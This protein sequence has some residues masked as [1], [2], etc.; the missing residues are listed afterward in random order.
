MA[1]RNNLT[2]EKMNRAIDIINIYL[3]SDISKVIHSS[4]IVYLLKDIYNNMFNYI[5]TPVLKE[6][7]D[8]IKLYF[9]YI[10]I[11]FYQPPKMLDKYSNYDVTY[12]FTFYY[13]KLSLIFF[14]RVF[15]E[16]K[17]KSLDDL[18]KDNQLILQLGIHFIFE[19]V[20]NNYRH[21]RVE[22]YIQ[23]MTNPKP[24][25]DF[26]KSIICGYL[27][28]TLIGLYAKDT[29][30][31]I[32]INGGPD[33]LDIESPDRIKYFEVKSSG[34]GEYGCQ[35]FFSKNKADPSR[36]Y[37]CLSVEH[38]TRMD[39]DHVFRFHIQVNKLGKSGPEAYLCDTLK[40]IDINASRL[41]DSIS[42][43]MKHLHYIFNELTTFR[44]RKISIN[45]QNSI[46]MKIKHAKP[47]QI[48]LNHVCIHTWSYKTKTRDKERKDRISYNNI[49]NIGTL[50]TPLIYNI[51]TDKQSAELLETSYLDG[52][53]MLFNVHSIQP[54]EEPA[55]YPNLNETGKFDVQEIP[56]EGDAAKQTTD[57][58]AAKQT[59]EL[60]VERVR[61]QAEGHAALKAHLIK[62]IDEILLRIT[63]SPL[64][65]PTIDF[66][67]NF[68]IIKQIPIQ[69][70]LFIYINNIANQIHPYDIELKRKFMN[71]INLIIIPY[72]PHSELILLHV[73]YNLINLRQQNITLLQNE[74]INIIKLL[75]DLVNTQKISYDIFFGLSINAQ[76][77]ILHYNPAKLIR[78]QIHG[79]N[80]II[81]VNSTIYNIL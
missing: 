74:I 39:D 62:Q 34:G 33:I 44:D 29:F 48:L 71:D 13:L 77:V 16:L 45:L 6:F 3:S 42:I 47:A 20:Y 22:E 75:M 12:Y 59:S 7:N 49:G 9:K 72:H 32:H 15:A 54:V 61:T 66:F 80:I 27:I 52:S 73:L 53:P 35:Q 78:P 18:T 65:P 5:F 19:I 64:T 24:E 31:I 50:P 26:W 28:E 63:R 67:N 70:K 1:T 21:D 8:D 46:Q 17:L 36:A 56:T 30:V 69:N 41:N 76:S 81:N 2:V 60:A 23:L 57:R 11:V 4:G 40:S 51:R 58:D 37:D 79:N 55:Y 68:L 10:T 43:C 14:K 25:F 38:I